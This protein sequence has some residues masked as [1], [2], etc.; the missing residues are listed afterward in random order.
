MI[1]Q[2]NIDTVFLALVIWREAR[3][4]S[5]DCKTA[6]GFSVLARVRHGGWWGKDVQSVIF[7]KWQYSSMTAHNDPNLVQWPLSTEPAWMRCIVIASDI[8]DGLLVNP[9][10]GADSYFDDSITAPAWA[11]KGRFITKIG[12]INFYATV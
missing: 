8:I 5:D 2:N 10:P 3:G 1:D 9:A 12:R 7:H 6:V 4:E 11:R